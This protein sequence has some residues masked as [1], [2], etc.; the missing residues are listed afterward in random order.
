M[1]PNI[2]PDEGKGKARFQWP[3]SCKTSLRCTTS[4]AQ[5]ASVGPLMFPKLSHVRLL[6]IFVEMFAASPDFENTGEN[7]SLS[8]CRT[9]PLFFYYCLVFCHI[10]CTSAVQLGIKC[11]SE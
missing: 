8:R 2:H 4:E 6:L 3:M 11:Y 5:I 1:I 9:I 10:L 7:V